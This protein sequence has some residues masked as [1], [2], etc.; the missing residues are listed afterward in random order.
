[1][2]NGFIEL[3]PIKILLYLVTQEYSLKTRIAR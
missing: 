1:M 3:E 2:T